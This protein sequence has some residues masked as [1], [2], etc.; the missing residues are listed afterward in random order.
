MMLERWY[1]CT[2]EVK[3]ISSNVLHL[4]FDRPHNSRKVK[5]QLFFFRIVEKNDTQNKKVEKE[6][7]YR[8]KGKKI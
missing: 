8:E 5:H 6:N 7:M 4:A 1:F 3:P 2:L